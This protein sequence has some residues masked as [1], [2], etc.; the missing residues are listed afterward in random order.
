MPFLM[1]EEMI[2]CFYLRSFKSLKRSYAKSYNFKISANT[3]RSLFGRFPDIP[4]MQTANVPIGSVKVP[5]FFLACKLFQGLSSLKAVIVLQ[6][7]GQ[8]TMISHCYIFFIEYE[9]L[10]VFNNVL[11]EIC[12][13]ALSWLSFK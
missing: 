7:K 5:F 10:N 13:Q 4:A 3:F 2:L 6:T 9:A 11:Y 1:H 12:T 8:I